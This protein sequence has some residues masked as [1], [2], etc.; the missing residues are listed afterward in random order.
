MKLHTKHIPEA[1]AP[2][3]YFYCIFLP[4]FCCSAIP[5]GHDNLFRDIPQMNNPLDTNQI[6]EKMKYQ[7]MMMKWQWV[8]YTCEGLLWVTVSKPPSRGGRSAGIMQPSSCVHPVLRV[9]CQPE[10]LLIRG[11]DILFGRK[12]DKI[13]SVLLLFGSMCEE[14]KSRAVF[15][16]LCHEATCSETKWFFFLVLASIKLEQRY[17]LLKL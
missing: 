2:V 4:C 8:T 1:F 10:L 14:T 15:V 13:S 6:T 5:A 9:I 3:Y 7:T 16:Y 12:D 11:S 17:N